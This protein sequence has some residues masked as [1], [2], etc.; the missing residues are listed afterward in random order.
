MTL[1]AGEREEIKG[2]ARSPNR[3]YETQSEEG[4]TSFTLL[5]TG[6]HYEWELLALPPHQVTSVSLDAFRAH[7]S[8]YSISRPWQHVEG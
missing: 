4:P 5:F 2:G 7:L 1:P 8:L 6:T 3:G